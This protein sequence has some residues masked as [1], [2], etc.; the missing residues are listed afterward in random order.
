MKRYCYAK[1]ELVLR[2]VCFHQETTLLSLRSVGTETIVCFHQRIDLWCPRSN[3]T[4]SIV[5]FHQET[6]LFCPRDVATEL[7]CSMLF[8]RKRSIILLK[9]VLLWTLQASDRKQHYYCY[10]NKVLQLTRIYHWSTQEIRVADSI[11]CFPQRNIK[12]FWIRNYVI[13]PT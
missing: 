11:V 8:F 1:E 3:G 6:A 4:E 12:Q 5:C 7:E 13:S 9:L 10:R 2:T